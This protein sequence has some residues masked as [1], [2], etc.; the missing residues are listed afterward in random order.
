MIPIELICRELQRLTD[1]YYKCEN[2]EMK[3]LIHDD[4]KIL[5][6]TLFVSD[7]PE[8]TEV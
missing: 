5:S 2:T 3:N 7:L 6:Y 8:E 1:D 4:I